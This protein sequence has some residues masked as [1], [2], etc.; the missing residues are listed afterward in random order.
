MNLAYYII[1]RL[2]V[3]VNDKHVDKCNPSVTSGYD[4]NIG[5]NNHGKDYFLAGG[6]G[7]YAPEA[8][9][10][11]SLF[12]VCS[13]YLRRMRRKAS[14]PPHPRRNQRLM[15]PSGLGWPPGHG[16]PWPLRRTFPPPT[17]AIH[18]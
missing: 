1:S 13:L 12:M 17:L 5:G 6:P 7:R 2:A 14:A 8:S 11:I 18:P 4:R 9:A 15:I 16:R 10:G 3:F